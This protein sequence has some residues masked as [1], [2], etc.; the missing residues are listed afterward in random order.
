MNSGVEKLSTKQSCKEIRVDREGGHLSVGQGKLHPAIVEDASVTVLNILKSC[1]KVRIN[2][3]LQYDLSFRPENYCNDLFSTFYFLILCFLKKLE[4]PHDWCP[5][6]FM[7]SSEVN[8][9]K[10]V[11]LVWK[12]KLSLDQRIKIGKSVSHLQSFQFLSLVFCVWMLQII[13]WQISFT[14]TRSSSNWWQRGIYCLDSKN[15]STFFETS[16]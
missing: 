8:S 9:L 5:G 3:R 16:L 14:V 12:K 4:T 1:N 11:C 13:S 6:C 2:W 15:I 10:S 7:R